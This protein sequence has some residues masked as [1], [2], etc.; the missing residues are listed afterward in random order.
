MLLAFANQVKY[1]ASREMRLQVEMKRETRGLNKVRSNENSNESNATCECL[2]IIITFGIKYF[3]GF[4][5]TPVAISRFGVTFSLEIH[6]LGL[7]SCPSNTL[8]VWIRAHGRSTGHRY[9]IRIH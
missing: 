7:L 6:R 9:V 8:L 1:G 3:I 5:S 4:V 2:F